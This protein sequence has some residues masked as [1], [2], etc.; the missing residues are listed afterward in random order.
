MAECD[1]KQAYMHKKVVKGMKNM[2]FVHGR[3]KL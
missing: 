2:S 1:K 3:P